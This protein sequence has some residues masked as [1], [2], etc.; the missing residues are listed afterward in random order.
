MGFSVSD[1]RLDFSSLFSKPACQFSLSV[2]PACL[3]A[4]LTFVCSPGYVCEFWLQRGRWP[5][6]E[7]L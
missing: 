7:L 1:S 4:L 5:V 6:L 3:S 2:L